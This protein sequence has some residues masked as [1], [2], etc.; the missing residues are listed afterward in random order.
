MRCSASI[1]HVQNLNVRAL[2][3]AVPIAVKGATLLPW[4]HP[5]PAF[6]CPYIQTLW[7]RAFCILTAIL[8]HSYCH[9]HLYHFFRI[10]LVAFQMAVS[11]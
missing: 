6:P 1:Q 8:S 11:T 10:L 4:L 2:P 9:Y 7:A 3:L 5:T